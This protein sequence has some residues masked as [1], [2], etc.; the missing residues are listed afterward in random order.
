M[1]IATETGLHCSLVVNII[2]DDITDRVTR[3]TGRA[4]APSFSTGAKA[5]TIIKYAIRIERTKK[6][7]N[8]QEF[9]SQVPTS[10]A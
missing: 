4:A 9:T 5:L 3:G 1:Q 7:R 2:R 8:N 6:P 10:S